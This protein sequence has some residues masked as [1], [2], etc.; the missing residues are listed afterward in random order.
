[1]SEAPRKRLASLDQFR[2]YTVAGMFL[3]NFVGRYNEMHPLLKHHSTYC[4][5]ADTIMPQ[6]FFAVGFAYRLTFGRRLHTEGAAV[7]YG[8]VIRR[9]LGLGLLA[10]VLYSADP[11][12][13][14]WNDWQNLVRTNGYEALFYKSFKQTWFQTLLHIAVTSLWLLPVIRA[15]WQARV[16]YGLA[17]AILHLFLSYWFYFD[18]AH[19]SPGTIDGGP[20][21][22]LTW[23]IPTLAGTLACDA[24]VAEGKPKTGRVFLWGLIFMA[25]GWGMS[26]LTRLYD[27]PVETTAQL[28]AEQDAIKQLAESNAKEPDSTKKEQVA[29]EIE[30]RSKKLR[31][32]KYASDAVI[33]NSSRWAGKSL[34]SLICEPPFVPPPDEFHRQRNYWQMSQMDGTISYLVFSTGISLALYVLFYFISDVAGLQIGVFRTLGTNA[35]FG[36][37]IHG[38]VDSGVSPFFP[39][40]S[41]ILAAWISFVIYFFICW[42]FIRTLEKQKIYI[43][44]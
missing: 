40:D 29:A 17:S 31:S 27:C 39:K 28:I 36:Y 38:I 26:G 15:G 10:I 25:L 18:W 20:L 43:R 14:N 8:R 33:P 32:G 24:F 11:V 7:A 16:L 3:V 21:G 13:Q 19:V 44:L 9:F 35:L 22:F 34:G 2:G 30:E 12:A 23:S 37:V 4:S 41:P 42:L 6:F 5:Y 1:M